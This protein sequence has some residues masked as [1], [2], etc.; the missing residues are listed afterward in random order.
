M[1]RISRKER[2]AS[3]RESMSQNRENTLF[4]DVLDEYNNKIKNFD[5]NLSNELKEILQ[6]Q[7][8]DFIKEDENLFNLNIEDENQTETKPF[9]INEFNKEFNEK[10]NEEKTEE[11]DDNS[12]DEFEKRL[13]D[14]INKILVDKD[15]DEISD[16]SIK[17]LDNFIENEEKELEPENNENI[18]VSVVTKIEE[19]I[20]AIEEKTIKKVVEP[21]DENE[22]VDALIDIVGPFDDLKIK[23]RKEYIPETIKTEEVDNKEEIVEDVVD[24]NNE[25]DSEVSE[26]VIDENNEVNENISNE[27]VEVSE[28]VITEDFKNDIL[29]EVKEYNH[30]EGNTTLEEI[31]NQMIKDASKDELSDT[32]TQEI[33]KVLNETSQDTEEEKIED[34]IDQTEIFE[35]PVLAK[36]EGTVEILPM[37]ETL[38]MDVV[39]DTI[40]FKM[41]EEDEEEVEDE[42]FSKAVNIV[43]IVL[44][45]ILILI[46]A[47]IGYFIFQI[48]V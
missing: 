4:T 17:K 16:D 30:K 25:E 45:V 24:G 1:T 15:E 32:V 14:V 42:S 27:A 8:P 10:I 20:V 3:K 37:E 34:A 39:D 11:K 13:N 9:D 19:P 18:E 21:I 38:K 23:E 7:E 6:R 28:E 29:D 26:D 41:V 44:I 35:H 22:V 40:P 36:E 48:G 12:V 5:E 31:P 2:F 47:L 46:L 33:D 43:L